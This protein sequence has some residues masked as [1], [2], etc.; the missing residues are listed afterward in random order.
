MRRTGLT[1]I[2]T[3]VVVAVLGFLIGLLLPAVQKAC[4]AATRTDI[5]NRTRQIVLGIHH[6][7]ADRGGSLPG[8]KVLPITE[9]GVP[10]PLFNILPYLE[11]P[12][13]PPY[14]NRFQHANGGWILNYYT[15]PFYQSPGDPTLPVPGERPHATPRTNF[16][17]NWPL[18]G[19][20]PL[21]P[22]SV[23]DGTAQTIAVAEKY[24][25]PTAHRMRTTY[26]FWGPLSGPPGGP[27]ADGGRSGTFADPKYLDVVPVTS[28]S[29]PVSRPSV[30]GVTFQAAPRPEDADG[31]ML[32]SSFPG[33][34]I[35]GMMDG[36]TRTLR[37]GIAVTAFWAA[38]TPAAGD[39]A[40]LD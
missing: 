25:R 11:P 31:R 37:P 36:H 22:A 28:D 12:F 17:V 16:A 32:Q 39:T 7:A 40:T 27:N 5:T 14:Y 10:G 34:L 19:G 13:P 23:S 1:V 6:Y 24:Y 29:P 21:L 3:L 20:A 2:E 26:L 15:F 8:Y 30:A 9:W 33:G 35:V 18:F 38:V 4:R